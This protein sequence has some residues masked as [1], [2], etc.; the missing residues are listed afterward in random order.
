M[1]RPYDSELH[2]STNDN[3]LSVRNVSVYADKNWTTISK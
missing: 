2:N 3:Q 1:L